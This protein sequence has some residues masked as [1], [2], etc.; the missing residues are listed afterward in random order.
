M[1]RRRRNPNCASGQLPQNPRLPT[2]F[3]L[4]IRKLGLNEQTCENSEALQR[5]CKRNKNHCYV[6]EWLLEWWG[7]SVDAELAG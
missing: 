4:E 6:P 3:E 1:S 2:A 5:W 7:M